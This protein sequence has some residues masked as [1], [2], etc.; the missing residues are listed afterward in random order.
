MTGKRA[1]ETDT[2]ESD[3]ATRAEPG[4]RE[5]LERAASIAQ[6]WTERAVLGIVRDTGGPVITRPRC[7]GSA[8]TVPDTEALTGLRTAAGVELRAR[9]LARG[10]IRTAREDGASWHEIGAALD[11]AANDEHDCAAEAAFGYAAPA[12]SYYAR[13]YGPTCNWRCP[14]CYGLI[15][16]LGPHQGSPARSEEMH[17]PGCPRLAADVATYHASRDDE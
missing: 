8:A 10:Y 15:R 6:A 16:D 7:P 3:D 1:G 11:L 14:A 17:G 2:G 4:A 5:A 12:D 9:Q 13:I